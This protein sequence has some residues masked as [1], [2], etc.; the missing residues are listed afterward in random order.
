[1]SH[2]MTNTDSL[3]LTGR[4]A[5]HGLGTIVADAPTPGEALKVAKLDWTV[6]EVEIYRSPRVLPE[7]GLTTY[8][9]IPGYQA[10]IRSDTGEAFQVSSDGYSVFQNSELAQLAQSVADGSGGRAEVESFGSIRSG[11]VVYCLL[12]TGSFTVG[13]GGA[14]RTETYCLLSN[15]HDGTRALRITPTSV[16]V[17]CS[18]T[19]HA[20][21]DGKT[22]AAFSF[23]H[24]SG[25]NAAVQEALAGLDVAVQAGERWAKQAQELGVKPLDGQARAA[26]FQAAYERAY[27][28]LPVIE[29]EA[30]AKAHDKAEAILRRWVVNLEDPNQSIGGTQGT[31]WAC[32]NAITQWADHEG[33]TRATGSQ[34]REDAR[35][36]SNLVGRS[37]A[38]KKAALTEALALI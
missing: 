2:E 36:A 10:I 32:L 18:N 27:G 21:D 1:M 26:F 29:T 30:H 28:K 6:D 19:L 5:W 23:R 15:A 16:R 31:A 22:G 9:Q 33:R 37:A 13:I 7:G 35:V 25:L 11:R 14:D 24:T 38:T 34:T 17:V 12:R 4:R 3:V 8:T 20:A